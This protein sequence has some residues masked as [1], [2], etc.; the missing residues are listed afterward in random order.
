MGSKLAV[1]HFLFLY[2]RVSNLRSAKK[3][4]LERLREWLRGKGEGEGHMFLA[5]TPFESKTW[6]EEFMDDDFLLLDSGS[7]DKDLF[8]RDV[9]PLVIRAARRMGFNKLKVCSIQPYRP[10]EANPLV[11]HPSM[12]VVRLCTLDS[13]H[14]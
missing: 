8:S 14:S 2:S 13:R 5:R 3:T 11:R 9:S 1:D 10:R 7:D 12:R 6:G 4:D